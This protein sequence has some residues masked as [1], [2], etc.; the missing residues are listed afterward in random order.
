MDLGFLKELKLTDTRGYRQP[1]SNN[2]EGGLKLRV[3]RNGSVYPSKELVDRFNLEYTEKGAAD[4]GNG[5]DLVY[6]KEWEPMKTTTPLILCAFV[7]RDES[8]LDLFRQVRYLPA[9]TEGKALP[10]KSVMNQG[11]VCDEL[12]AMCDKMGYFTDPKVKYVDLAIAMDYPVT[13][14]DNIYYLPKTVSRG[15][16]KDEETYVRR[17]NIILYPLIPV[18]SVVVENP[19]TKTI[20]EAI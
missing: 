18:N 5:I 2:P 7:C 8:K 4:P 13:T 3:F 15:A 9:N 20:K 1:L 19:Q 11:L 17:E 16:R 6:T 10:M 14:E 12:L